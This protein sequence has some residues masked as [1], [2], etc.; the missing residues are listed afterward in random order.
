MEIRDGFIFEVVQSKNYIEIRDFDGNTYIYKYV[1][2]YSVSD[3]VK[4]ILSEKEKVFDLVNLKNKKLQYYKLI[5]K[6]L[7]HKESKINKEKADPG[8]HRHTGTVEDP[9][10][11]INNNPGIKIRH[12]ISDETG[13]RRYII[14]PLE[15]GNLSGGEKISFAHYMGLSLAHTITVI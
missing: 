10:P 9:G 1:E 11:V 2:G 12:V 13:K 5:K 7:K 3:L 8:S 15:S 6:I 4:I 14:N